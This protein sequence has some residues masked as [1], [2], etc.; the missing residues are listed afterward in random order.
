MT[1][2]RRLSLIFLTTLAVVLLGFSVTLYLLARNYLYRQA[3]DHL[4]S[5]LD[6]LAVG[7]ES[8]PGG[9]EWEPNER[10][11]PFRTAN[12]PV[13]WQISDESHRIVDKQGPDGLEHLLA[14]AGKWP[15]LVHWQG[16]NWLVAERQLQASGA[17]A[18]SAGEHRYTA[19]HI[20]AAVSLKP[21]ETTLLRLAG[22]LV[23]VSGTIW[24]VALAAAW[25]VSRRALRPIHRMAQAAR[26]MS[27]AEM[28]QR[29]PVST[30]GDE[31]EDLSRAFNGLLDRLQDSFE[32]QQRFAGQASHQ[33]RTPL[34]ALL[35]QVEVTLRRPRG[36]EEY[37]EALTAVH[38]QGVHL[39]K[40]VEAL[41]F[42][43]RAD[44]EANLPGLEA[45]ALGPWLEDHM[46]S[47]S[48]NARAE[49]IHIEPGPAGL[50]TVRA[51]PVLLGE[52]VNVLVENACKYSPPGT[53]ISL[54]LGR[55][56]SH[57]CLTVEDSGPGI[58]DEDMPH[59]CE[60]F[61][62]AADVRRRGIAGVGLGLAIARR[63]ISAFGGQLAVKSQAG[64]G[65]QFIVSLP[66]QVESSGGAGD[67]VVGSA[68]A[69]ASSPRP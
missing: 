6:T 63:L 35:G 65:S 40:I 48:G 27:A 43:T 11:L 20:A 21:V 34:T 45:I 18:L 14:S 16:G 22:A 44:A 41:L 47:W 19:L 64:Q 58:A 55:E 33:L 4:V 5:A 42:L 1:L 56:G 50:P 37:R 7:V 8:G 26:S 9:L 49:D 17:K 39:R 69:P 29:L 32:R 2:T 57:V 62:R 28:G 66:V 30:T 23:V 52:V 54:R 53:P 67:G 10:V 59:V 38:A 24:V 46:A 31:L 60:P 13:V 25:Y 68:C 15:D 3:G 12:S 61:F 51:Q 36:A